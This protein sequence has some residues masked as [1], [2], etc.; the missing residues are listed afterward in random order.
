MLLLRPALS[1]AIVIGIV[2]CL[3]GSN[4]SAQTLPSL[5]VRTWRP[6][7]DPAASLVLE[8]A[9]TPGSWNWNVGAWFTYANQPVVLK[10]GTLTAFR[11]VD[12]QVGA[13]LTASLGLF[14]RAAVGVDLPTFLFQDGSSNV[15]STAVTSGHVA[16][17]GLGDLAVT[18]KAAILTNDEGG[19]GL[20]VLGAV[21]LPTGN[22]QSFEGEGS[23]TVTA[24]VLA[25]ISI[26]IA[27]LQASLGYKL[28][29]DH[30]LWPDAT[31][32][33]IF[34]DEI[35]WSIGILFHPGIVRVLDRE[36]RQS[37][38]LALHGS[39]PAGPVGPFGTGDPGSQALSPVLLAFSDRIELGHDRDLYTVVGGD[40][41]LGNAVGVPTFRGVVSIGWAPRNHDRDH[42][43]VPDDVDQCPGIAED[44]DGFE[45]TDGCPDMDNDDD[46]IPDELDACPN[47]KGVLDAD[48]KRN[49]CPPPQDPAPPT[50][51]PP[52]AAPPTPGPANGTGGA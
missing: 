7:T 8:P 43:G 52:T 9:A 2:V 19:F 51:A 37:W 29:T 31:G 6:S 28:R 48:P 16:P 25:D 34:G 17:T 18:G 27:S 22:R 23:A 50:A 4:A 20:A 38:E 15:P 41:G 11:P 3:E 32:G 13:D 24:R 26:V 36:D 1:V 47:I 12:N 45:D 35:P 14:S 30:H 46:G 21:T 49:G 42:D 39:L 44:R 40:V 5:D 10:Q 33:V